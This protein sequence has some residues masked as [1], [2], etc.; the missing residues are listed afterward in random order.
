MPANLTQ[1][2]PAL[3]AAPDDLWET[4]LGNHDQVVSQYHDCRNGKR[5]LIA[6]VQDWER[7]AWAWYCAALERMEL[8]QQECASENA[9]RQAAGRTDTPAQ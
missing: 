8:K 7:T 2:C 6:A 3:P 1:P 5:R 9:G 4:L